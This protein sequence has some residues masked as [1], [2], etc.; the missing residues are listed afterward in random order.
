VKRFDTDD[1]YRLANMFFPDDG[2]LILFNLVIEVMNGKL[3]YEVIDG[4]AEV[5]EEDDT[6][7]AVVI[8]MATIGQIPCK[9]EWTFDE[10]HADKKAILL[11]LVRGLT[12]V[13]QPKTLLELERPPFTLAVLIACEGADGRFAYAIFRHPELDEE[14]ARMILINAFPPETD[15]ET[16]TNGK[17]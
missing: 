1:A 6:D 5:V 17:N 7:L 9:I 13:A 15:E 4:P 16:P 8:G 11:G 2:D 12:P 10:D 3:S 14:Q